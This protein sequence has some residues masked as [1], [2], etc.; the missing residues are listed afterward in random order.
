MWIAEDCIEDVGPAALQ[1]VALKLR[2]TNQ[3]APDYWV[4]VL[5]FI[6]FA[7]A[8]ASPNVPPP[9]IAEEI[10]SGNTGFGFSATYSDRRVLLDRGDGGDVKFIRCRIIF[11]RNPVRLRGV[12]FIDCVFDMPVTNSP[13]PMLTQVATELLASNFKSVVQTL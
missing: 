10:F 8:G 5:Q 12:Q 3:N 11:T 4:T 13:S 1:E 7:S 2:S 6:R 9:G